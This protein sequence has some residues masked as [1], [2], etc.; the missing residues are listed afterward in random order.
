MIHKRFALAIVLLFAFSILSPAQNP[1]VDADFTPAMSRVTGTLFVGTD[2]QP[3]GK[4]IAAGTFQVV[5]GYVRYNVARLNT[6]G[7]T[8]PTFNCLECTFVVSNAVVQPDGKILVS[9][10]VS[11]S[12]N[13]GKIIRLNADGSLDG[14]FNYTQGNYPFTLRNFTVKGIQPDGKI[15]ILTSINGNN[16]IARLNSDGSL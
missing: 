11:L 3:D 8:D 2:F 9:G 10:K 13:I 16:R 6:D 15:I 1:T 4:I 12:Q 14:S 5:N 7:T